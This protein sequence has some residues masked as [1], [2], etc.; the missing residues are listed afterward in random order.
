MEH[1]VELECLKKR[2]VLPGPL[3]IFSASPFSFRYR[4]AVLIGFVLAVDE[5]PP[6]DSWYWMTALSISHL[7]TVLPENNSIMSS[8]AI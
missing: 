7:L 1:G 2:Q 3:E 6:C 5:R 8:L 4:S